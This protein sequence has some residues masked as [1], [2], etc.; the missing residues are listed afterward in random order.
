MR[1][2]AAFLL[3]LAL[4]VGLGQWLSHDPGLVTV[5]HGDRLVRT[6]LAVAIVLAL[7][8]SLAV[9]FT[10]RLL[11]RLLTVRGRLR[12][13]R[14]QRARRRNHERLSDGLLALAAGE[15][16][17]AERLLA[18]A[19]GPHA[20]AAHYLAA[21]QAAHAQAAPSR[22]DGYLSLAREVAPQADL[23]ILLQQVEMQL[24]AGE[25][26]AADAALRALEER[27]GNHR[28][29]LSLRHRQLAAQGAWDEIA[30]LLPRL[31]RAQ[32]Y[33]ATRVVELEA[34]VAARILARPYAD[35]AAL[36]SAW[37]ALPK[38]VRAEPVAIAAYARVLLTHDA[39][40]QAEAAL[41]KAVLGRWDARLLAL[42]GELRPPAAQDALRH[43]EHWL[44][45]HREDPALLTA[46]GRLCLTEQLWGKAREYLEAALAR[47]PSA[48]LHRLLADAL[49]RLHDAEGA[50]RQRQLGLE[51]A[52]GQ[53]GVPALPG[54]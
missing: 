27:H 38:A 28:Q 4:A 22:R 19:S 5:M 1:V 40:A 18:Q 2:L 34:E 47:A 7:A 49:E 24:A 33:P 36:A 13:W 25:I 52:T 37:N 15:Y 30:A 39:Q 35:L 20:S 9:Y 8:A 50:A 31:K 23:A 45:D 6:T 53:A 29:V 14:H 10:G 41:R 26:T 54:S 12:Q 17:R 11:W 16:A 48:M 46:L 51:L 42:Y 3:A 43:A 32:A 21:A 44:E